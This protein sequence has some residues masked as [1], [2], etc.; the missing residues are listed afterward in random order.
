MVAN[1]ED[2]FCRVV[3][4]IRKS[5]IVAVM[6]FGI[7]ASCRSSYSIVSYL[8]IYVSFSGFITSV[9]EARANFLLSF[10]CNYMVSVRMGFFFLLKLEIG[11]VI[12]LFHPQSLPYNNS[13]SE[14][15]RMFC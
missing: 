3:V 4:H 10:T 9:G 11:C 6:S 12:I 8:Y 13:P 1:P 2:R 14:V 5:R 15:I 7:G